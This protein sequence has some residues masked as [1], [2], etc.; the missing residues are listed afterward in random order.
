MHTFI[1]CFSLQTEKRLMS[2]TLLR[3]EYL[4]RW[5]STKTQ[6]IAELYYLVVMMVVTRISNRVLYELSSRL[7]DY[8]FFKD[9]CTNTIYN[10]GLLKAN[11]TKFFKTHVFQT[12][13]RCNC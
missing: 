2:I 11:L 8:L 6:S 12:L 7:I 5:Y 9:A 4:R 13:F 1:G 3:L 10:F